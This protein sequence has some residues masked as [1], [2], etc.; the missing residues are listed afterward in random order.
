MYPSRALANTQP[1]LRSTGPA[2][3]RSTAASSIPGAPLPACPA[4]AGA[5][6]V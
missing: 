2:L 1:V 4:I 6:G 5:A 3:R